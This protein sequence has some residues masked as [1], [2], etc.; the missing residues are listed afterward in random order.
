MVIDDKVHSSEP[1]ILSEDNPTYR[2]LTLNTT[3]Y[4]EGHVKLDIPVIH[5]NHVQKVGTVKLLFVRPL[6]FSTENGC[7]RQVDLQR[8]GKINI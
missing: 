7:K 3:L 8:R 4:K 2:Y 1:V 5:D 6:A